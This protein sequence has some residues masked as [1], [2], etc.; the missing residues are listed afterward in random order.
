MNPR[1]YRMERC[2]RPRLKGSDA[3]SFQTK[4]CCFKG[5]Y[6][7]LF[8]MSGS[9]HL[10]WNQ[11]FVLWGPRDLWKSSG[12]ALKK[13]EK[14]M[15]LKIWPHADLKRRGV[16]HLA[17]PRILTICQMHCFLGFGIISFSQGNMPSGKP[18]VSFCWL[19]QHFG[20]FCLNS[21]F[22]S[23]SSGDV[24]VTRCG[25]RLGNSVT[26]QFGLKAAE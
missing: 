5:R 22:I 18:Q 12:R 9:F 7:M 26:G 14:P 1:P 8:C 23:T 16:E 10:V 6:C 2:G 20:R 24:E 25:E 3:E 21:V 4:S 15:W 17:Q 11:R 13:T 19:S